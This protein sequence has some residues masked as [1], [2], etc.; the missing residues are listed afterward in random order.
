MA[1][2]LNRPE[3]TRDVLRDGWFHSGDIGYRDADGY[4][5]IVDRLKDMINCAGFKV[6]PREVEEVL[7]QHEAVRECAV[8]GAPD[9]LKG[10]MVAAFV[11]PQP[12]VTISAESLNEYCAARLA[13]YKV[14]QKFVFGVEIPKSP[15]GK[16]LKRVLRDVV[17]ASW[18]PSA[19]GP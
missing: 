5:F 16:I 12:G 18:G 2:Y 11:T 10:E 3:E 13:R 15:S 6:W 1:G 19:G 14:P 17:L 8:V 9:P 4:Y 7:H